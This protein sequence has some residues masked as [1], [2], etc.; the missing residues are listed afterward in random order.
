MCLPCEARSPVCSC[1]PIQLPIPFH[2]GI[3]AFVVLS[4]LSLTAE[5]QEIVEDE[6]GLNEARVP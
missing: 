2:G 6:D 1:V 3:A 5:E 4:I